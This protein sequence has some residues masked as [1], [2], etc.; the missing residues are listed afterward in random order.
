[1]ARPKRDE[2]KAEPE[3]KRVSAEIS[4]FRLQNNLSQKLFAEIIKV[5]R[6]TVQSIEAAEILP[7]KATLEKFK[8]LRE[9]YRAE[10][11]PTGEVQSQIASN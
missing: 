7:Q 1:M 4:N 11:R 3:I 9:K 6:R 5:S 10:G 2:S 8:E